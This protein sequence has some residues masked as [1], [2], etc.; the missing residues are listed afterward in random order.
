[1]PLTKNALEYWDTWS[2]IAD[3]VNYS[4]IRNNYRSGVFLHPKK[5]AWSGPDDSELLVNLQENN[6]LLRINA[7]TATATALV[8]YGVKDHSIVP[9]D[10]NNSDKTCNLKTYQD[11]FAM[12]NPDTIATLRFNDKQYVVTANE[13][14]SRKFEGF[15]DKN[16]A[17]TLFTVRFRL[18]VSDAFSYAVSILN[19]VFPHSCSDSSRAT[20]FLCP[21]SKS[22]RGEAL[23]C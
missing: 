4:E 15:A 6:G 17:N 3:E 13:G 10:I 19:T 18:L 14:D 21:A 12:R 1:M 11:L 2:P 16:K 7:T 8:S 20:H 9:V 23:A 22:R 5:L